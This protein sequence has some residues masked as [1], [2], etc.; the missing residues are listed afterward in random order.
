MAMEGKRGPSVVIDDDQDNA[1]GGKR[2]APE[3]RGGTHVSPGGAGS[4]STVAKMKTSGVAASEIY[5]D[6]HN[7][8]VEYIRSVVLRAF[9]QRNVTL[10]A[11]AMR[12]AHDHGFDLADVLTDLPVMTSIA[13]E[14]NAMLEDGPG[15]GPRVGPVLVL[16]IREALQAQR[17]DGFPWK[18]GVAKLE[19]F[20]PLIKDSLRW[21]AEREQDSVVAASASAGFAPSATAM[22]FAGEGPRL[23]LMTR[24]VNGFPSLV[25]NDEMA[26]TVMSAE[27]LSEDFSGKIVLNFVHFSTL[28]GLR[29]VWTRAWHRI[30]AAT[31]L[32]VP[33]DEGTSY[34]E[35]QVEI[36]SSMRY[37]LRD[38][39]MPG[40][41][42]C[43]RGYLRLAVTT[44]P[45]GHVSYDAWCLQID[46]PSSEIP[47]D[48]PPICGI[49]TAQVSRESTPY[50]D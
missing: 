45:R 44:G 34:R 7:V 48:P 9:A 14:V 31:P 49:G 27:L 23:L 35:T 17:L 36:H 32:P 1:R 16:H 22:E 24:F 43:C 11:N 37:L 2:L 6:M 30:A 8:P 4:S 3:S 50:R 38:S 40:R 29:P 42:F 19:A 28:V 13:A 15:T 33:G 5:K 26:S 47:D 39:S 20:P 12:L 18:G 25:I 10:L 21:G 46:G 41:W